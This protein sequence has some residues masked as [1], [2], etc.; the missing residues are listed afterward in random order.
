[1][2]SIFSRL[3]AL[4]FFL[5]WALYI[6]DHVPIPTTNGLVEPKNGHILNVARSLMFQA[7]LPQSYWGECVLAASYI[8]NRT[9]NPF[10]QHHKTRFEALFHR[11]PSYKHFRVIE[12]LCYASVLPR[13]NKFSPIATACVLLGYSSTQKGYKLLELAT[14]RYFVSR[15]MNFHEHIFPLT[16]FSPS[17]TLFVHDTTLDSENIHRVPVDATESIPAPIAPRRSSRHTV[18]PG[19]SQDSVSPTIS[20]TSTLHP[21]S[22]H[23]TYSHISPCE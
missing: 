23:L 14:N 13:A 1:M 17:T 22:N 6:K 5:H 8:I 18:P 7:S 12:C 15:D 16:V 19:W 9:P 4:I 21:L 20:N 10:L 11:L 3:G 2:P